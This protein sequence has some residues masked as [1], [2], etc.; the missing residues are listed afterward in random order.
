MGTFDRWSQGIHRRRVDV[1]IL[2][3][4]LTSILQPLILYLNCSRTSYDKRIKLA[5]STT[6]STTRY[7]P[8]H[9]DGTMTHSLKSCQWQSRN[10]SRAVAF[11]RP[12]IA[13]KMIKC[14]K[15]GL[16]VKKLDLQTYCR[17]WIVDRRQVKSCY[18][19]E[20]IFRPQPNFV[21]ENDQSALQI[22]FWSK[23]IWKILI[24]SQIIE[25]Y[26]MVKKLWAIPLVLHSIFLISCDQCWYQTEYRVC[27][28]LGKSWIGNSYKFLVIFQSSWKIPEK[29]L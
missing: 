26:C 8:K 27:K 7:C 13:L 6:H 11:P 21:K 18:R 1:A 24:I 29:H 15:I 23:K 16:A 17:E 28:P 9:C 4:G 10:R 2:P 19:A 20:N 25:I 14:M 3:N 5:W 12:W 22:C